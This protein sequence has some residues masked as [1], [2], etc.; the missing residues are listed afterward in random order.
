MD[1]ETEGTLPF[2]SSFKIIHFGDS[3]LKDIKNLKKLN[4]SSNAT[5]NFNEK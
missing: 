2:E 3:L 5:Y 1:T 4:F